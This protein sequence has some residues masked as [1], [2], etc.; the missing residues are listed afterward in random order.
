VMR[1]SGNTDFTACSHRRT[2]FQVR[3]SFH[4]W[5]FLSFFCVPRGNALP[6]RMALF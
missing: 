1:V 4:F 3:F 2:F 6:F 5:H